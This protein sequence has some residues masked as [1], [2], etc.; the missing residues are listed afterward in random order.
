[1]LPIS[2]CTICKNEEH[3]LE[4]FFTALR[5]YDW[6]LIFVDTGSTDCSRD[7]ALKYTDKVFDFPWNNDFSAARNYAVSKASNDCI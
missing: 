4:R 7:I 3:N 5:K 1:M 2:V 6:E